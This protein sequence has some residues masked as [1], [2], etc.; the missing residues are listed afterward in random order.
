MVQ[1]EPIEGGPG[2]RVPLREDDD[3]AV[4]LLP[5]P[6]CERC[7]ITV[8]V[9]APPGTCGPIRGSLVDVPDC[10]HIAGRSDAAAPADEL[11]APS[12]RREALLRVLRSDECSGLCRRA[13]LRRM[14]E[15]DSTWHEAI[16][17]PSEISV[18][19]GTASDDKLEEAFL[20]LLERGHASHLRA[21][22]AAVLWPPTPGAPLPV[23]PGGGGGGASEDAVSDGPS[24][25][26]AGWRGAVHDGAGFS[27]LDV[28]IKTQPSARASQGGVMQQGKLPYAG[29][30]KDKHL[31]ARAPRYSMCLAERPRC[32]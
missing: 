3:G 30:G 18:P 10:P 21:H 12:A 7:A 9:R 29:A 25:G 1:W 32:P 19:R 15:A 16:S 24:D 11:G 17:A 27:A 23:S 31:K 14:V 2:Y 28:L 8:R 26:P 20:G 6:T 5:H 4:L 13:Q 22:A